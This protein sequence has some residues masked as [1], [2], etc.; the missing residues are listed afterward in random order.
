MQTP[1]RHPL[2]IPLSAVEG[3]VFPAPVGGMQAVMLAALQQLEHTQY[4]PAD[5]MRARQYRQIALLAQ[6]AARTLP[7]WR[8]RFRAAGFDPSREISEESWAALPILTRAEAHA[9]GAA[10]HCESLPKQH[11]AITTDRTSG[12]TG[13][14]LEVKRS[15]LAVFYWNVFALREEVWHA[16]DMA[17]KLAA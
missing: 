5:A 12:S 8:E 15:A 6:H 9:A 13:M 4:L 1:T 14:V 7:F 11:G 10:L 2:P 3:A 17:G 16:R